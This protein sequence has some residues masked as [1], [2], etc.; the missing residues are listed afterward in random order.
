M[1]GDPDPINSS[2]D[3]SRATA[4]ASSSLPPSHDNPQFEVDLDLV[5]T[6]PPEPDTQ[7]LN[8]DALPQAVLDSLADK[9]SDDVFQI[10]FEANEVENSPEPT[11]RVTRGSQGIFKPMQSTL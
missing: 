2:V 6:P 4:V 8:D 7:Y 11:R 9:F 5:T 3:S 1:I 10:I